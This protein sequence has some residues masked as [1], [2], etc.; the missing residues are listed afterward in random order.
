MLSH[1]N[2]ELSFV[3]T[4]TEPVMTIR[5]P[6]V[7]LKVEVEVEL[8]LEVEMLEG[9]SDGRKLCILG[10]TWLVLVRETLRLERLS[11]EVLK[12]A[13]IPLSA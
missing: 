7:K 2:F 4:R 3:T 13:L 12:V 10:T 6:V 11:I 5:R 8:E 1:F 9:S